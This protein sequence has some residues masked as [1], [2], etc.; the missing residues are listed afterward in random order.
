MLMHTKGILVMLPTSAMVLTG[1][2]ALDFS[3]GVSAEDNFGIG[4]FDRVM[5]PNGQAQYW[6]PTLEDACRVLLRALRPHLRR[7]GGALPAAGGDQRPGRPRRAHRPARRPWPAAGLRVVGDVFSDERNPERKKPFDIR[8]VMRAVADTDHE[9]LER[10][11]RWRGGETVGGLGRARRR[12][13]GLHARAGV[14]HAGPA[15]VRPGRRAAVVDLGHAVPA[16]GAQGGPRDQRGQRQPAARRAGQ[17]VRVRR[18]AGVD[19]ALA[20]GVRRRDRPG[21]HELLR[22]DRLRGGLALPRRR[23]RGVL[24]AAQPG[25]GDRRGRGLLRLGH[26]RGAGSGDRVRPRGPGAHRAGPAGGGAARR[27]RR[28]DRRRGGRRCGPSCCT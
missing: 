26:R 3:G 8:S 15:R 7:A 17:P 14:A 11:A 2:Q 18:L 10:W 27:D 13:P 12:H 25:H 22:P 23:V 16:V 5:G 19:A 9:P 24:E 4:G 21:G 20:A 1:K 6:A 28:R